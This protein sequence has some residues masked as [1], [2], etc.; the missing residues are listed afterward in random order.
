MNGV[1][2]TAA[3]LA[4]TSIVA[5]ALA[6]SPLTAQKGAADGQWR[7]YGG[8]PGHTRY[9]PLDQIDAG[10]VA[11][12]EVAWSWTARNYGPNPLVRS[13]TTPL[14]V[15]GVLYATA[16]QRRAVVALD[17]GSG[18]TLWMWTMDEGERLADAPR[19]NP[20]RG[21]AW[22]SDG[23]GDDRVLVMTPGYH[24]VALDAA[25]GVPVEGFG[26]SGTIDLHDG[27]RVRDGVPISGSIGS[28]SP[29]TVVG[30]VVVVGSAQHV[31]LRP[32]SRINTPG[33]VR[34]YDV[35]TGELLWTFHTIPEPGEEGHDTWL[36]GSAEY[37][38]NAGVWAP[39]SFDAETGYVYLPTEAATGDYYG[40]HRPG[41]N[42]FST[43]LVALDA[44][45]GRKVWHQQI[46]HHDIWDWDNPT[47]PILGDVTVDGVE[48]K[49]VAQ[50]TKQGF[51]YVFDRVTGEP[52]WPIVETAVPQTDVPGEWTSPT[53][54]I[55]TLPVPYERQGFS[56]DDLIDFTP[57][58]LQRAQEAAAAYRMG[59]IF[60]PPSL[61][62][63]PDGTNG[64]LSLP[65]TLGGANW[66][67]GAFDPESG[68]LYVG[69][70]TTAS[71]LQLVPGGERSDMD[72]VFGFARAD[73][74]PGVPIVK[75][76]W[77]RITALDLKDGSMAWMVPNGDTPDHVAQRLG[78]DPEL[79][80][81]TGKVSRAGL[82]VTRSLLFAGEGASG[83]PILRALD[84]AT[85][86]TIAEI[87][88]PGAQTGLPMTYMHEGRQYVVLSV[89]GG[90][91]SA[92]LV[93][94]AL[95]DRD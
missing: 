5:S 41:A 62:D 11:D 27:H 19:P 35:R 3:L 24:L 6:T 17:A 57:E 76:P 34:G 86:E 92:E 33:D 25:T 32:P 70:Q 65:S 43:S 85:G 61:R 28:S 84:K 29:P 40:G 48:R 8:D 80:P 1:A 69:S 87:E 71:V 9:A 10:N 14:Y 55:P 90:G 23:A 13:Q 7:V 16:G 37:T 42:L 67:G 49:I 58:I 82:L 68:M 52:I 72:Y 59:P 31:G 54:P 2:R 56:E 91:E 30:D 93:A 77:G 53:Q 44:R 88:L 47:F 79:I 38:G 63:A 51:T 12:L 22:W 46:I 18:E 21:V 83:D 20:G 94:F 95:P 64:T 66:E 26:A 50:L 74:A 89:G 78:I 60:S 73:V 15:D 45:T 81:R 39:I 75:P 4:A 36:E